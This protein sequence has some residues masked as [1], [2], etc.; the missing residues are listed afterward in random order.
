MSTTEYAYR[1]RGARNLQA[2]D[3][4]CTSTHAEEVHVVRQTAD[5][6]VARRSR[7][8]L[9]R[10]ATSE[11]SEQLAKRRRCEV[12]VSAS[13]RATTGWPCRRSA[14]TSAKRSYPI[15][16]TDRC[17]AWRDSH[18]R[19]GRLKTHAAATSREGRVTSVDRQRSPRTINVDGPP[20]LDRYARVD[21]RD[22]SRRPVH[23]QYA[24]HRSL[25]EAS[26]ALR[27]TW[28]RRSETPLPWRL[29]QLEELRGHF[30]VS[31]AA[32]YPNHPCSILGGS[33]AGHRY[34][35]LSCRALRATFF[36]AC[37]QR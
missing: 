18:S 28:Y 32:G 17:P 6:I 30:K 8:A 2:Y 12:R 36:G 15:R 1:P 19:R 22:A 37:D 9:R 27:T 31:S 23:E 21:D 26:P 13:V 5:E 35:L 20:C 34:R 33:T 7:A 25:R 10:N 16:Q 4:E 29:E 11:S 3:V 24:W 14:R